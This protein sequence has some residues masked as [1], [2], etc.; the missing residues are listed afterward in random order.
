M[1]LNQIR[2]IQRSR[3]DKVIPKTDMLS[4]P[5]RNGIGISLFFFKM[6]W[7]RIPVQGIPGLINE[8]KFLSLFFKSNHDSEKH[9]T[10]WPCPWT[11]GFYS[12]F[13]LLF[14]FRPFS[15]RRCRDG[16]HQLGSYLVD[17]RGHSH[18][19]YIPVALG[20]VSLTGNN[21]HKTNFH[22][23]FRPH[24]AVVHGGLYDRHIHRKM[25]PPQKNRIDCY[26]PHRDRS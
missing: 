24:G 16:G 2:R 9:P 25:E 3:P 4:L 12:Y 15:R 23:L 17:Y 21:G 10:D 5:K 6:I 7:V 26:I 13:T 18:C 8:E 1:I 11:F 14:S 19:R 22:C 20:A